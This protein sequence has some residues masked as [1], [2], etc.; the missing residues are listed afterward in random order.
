M[1]SIRMHEV[2]DLMRDER[3]KGKKANKAKQ[4]S[5]PKAVT[6][7][8]KNELPRVGLEPTTLY[9]LDRA[10]L[11]LSYQG[12]S[13]GW[14]Q[15][16]HLIVHPMNRQT[17]NVY[18]QLHTHTTHY[19]HYTTHTTHYPHYTLSQLHYSHYTLSQLHYSHYTLSQLHYSHYTLS[20]LHYSHYTTHTLHYSHTTHYPHYTTHC[21][22]FVMAWPF[23][24]ST[25]KLLVRVGKMRKATT[26]V[27]LLLDFRKWLSLASDSR[28]RSAP[29]LL[30]SY[31]V[32]NSHKGVNK[33][34]TDS[35]FLSSRLHYM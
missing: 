2:H 34:V 18:V 22:C 15:I 30:N 20:Q 32:G 17:I 25:L 29:L 19:P 9:T 33:K 24:L 26:V 16:S 12:S 13:A 10:P 4:H 1:G 31:L 5:T 3:R 27:L 23:R 28:N 21:S 8:K 6:F 7:P 11:P 35:Q 14:A